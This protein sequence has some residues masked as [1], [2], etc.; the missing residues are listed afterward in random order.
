[1]GP[2]RAVTLT[3]E[4]AMLL[5]TRYWLHLSCIWPFSFRNVISLDQFSAFEK[6]HPLEV[7]Y[8]MRLSTVLT[9][10]LGIALIYIASRRLWGWRSATLVTAFVSL[11]PFFLG[12]SRLLVTDGHV[13]TWTG[14]AILAFLVYLQRGTYRWAGVTILATA[15]ALISKP[16]AILLLG[17]L[18][19][20]SLGYGLV[21][22]N[23]QRVLARRI[24]WGS[25]AIGGIIGLWGLVAQLSGG[26]QPLF[27]I[28]RR[29]IH[30][31]F[32][33]PGELKFLLGKT[34]YDPAWYFYLVVLL[35]RTTPG[36][37]A[38]I[39]LG[40]IALF[41]MQDQ[42]QEETARWA[43]LVF[44]VVLFIAF[45]SVPGIKIGR[46]LLPIYPVLGVLAARGFLLFWQWAKCRYPP[47]LLRTVL[48][49]LAFSHFAGVLITFPYYTTYYTP[50]L[51]RRVVD[52]IQVGYGEGLDSVANHLNRKP[53]AD[54]LNV[55]SDHSREV[56]APRFK[57]NTWQV[58]TVYGDTVVT[59]Q[60]LH[61]PS[62]FTADYV[63]TY[64]NQ[65]Q[66]K[67]PDPQLI[68]YFL[69]RRPEME[70]R[71]AGLPYATVYPGPIYG[72]SVPEEAV[73][74]EYPSSTPIHLLAYQMERP[75]DTGIYALTFFWQAKTPLTQDYSV[76][77]KLLSADGQVWGSSDG[78]PVG[79]FLPTSLWEPGAVVR[80]D[81]LLRSLPGTPPGSYLLEASLVDSTTGE[82]LSLTSGEVGPGGSLVLQQVELHQPAGLW[83][84]DD[85][86]A[87]SVELPRTRNVAKGVRLLGY[88]PTAWED[89]RPGEPISIALL[90]QAT[91]S[92][93]P[94]FTIRWQFAREGERG[95]EIGRT[96]PG[97]DRYPL[98]N[99]RKHAIVRDQFILRLPAHL[100][101]GQ[102][103]LRAVLPDGDTL[104]IGSVQ[105]VAREHNF[106]IPQVAST[107]DISFGDV[108]RLL[109]YDL[110]LTQIETEGRVELTLFWQALGE[111]E[112]PYK[113]FVHLLDESGQIVAQVDREPQA[114]RAPSTG[115]LA[116][117][118]IMDE[119]TIPVT[120]ATAATRSIAVGLYDP[121]SGQRV[122]VLN[123]KGIEVSD[124]ATLLV[125]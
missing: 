77:I 114:G 55:L 71:L 7:L 108:A 89:M 12:F 31:Y 120:E 82:T 13:T 124:S 38:G 122:P 27:D 43:T 74:L 103:Q 59:P 66:R 1:M 57:G 110:D 107:L 49:S 23:T 97:T 17:F 46:Y 109:G 24:L 70:V 113:V 112:T 9:T 26:G 56:L 45:V 78:W 68:E 99:W 86:T 19:L 91:R 65:I 16:S 102:Y 10:A 121:S 36:I 11:D 101:S 37:W 15:L 4:S 115:W 118:V 104:E 3:W 93:P 51:G 125:P 20:A 92:A 34:A 61:T 58:Q 76:V 5:L 105:V 88:G 32:T 22:E 28:F 123:T 64:I 80:D 83:D 75:G 72:G 47:F 98:P 52:L 95:E 100:E 6:S 42:E 63:V 79:G 69:S 53:D 25:M 33:Y 18:P 54:T 30:N 106:D 62:F 119:I 117:E 35:A 40:I 67:L 111:T 116:S 60:N 84:D 39:C 87:L 8:T 73:S 14:V 48:V 50:L 21:M 85:A 90:W 94:D 96:S 41:K 44:F 2:F 29:T 81:H